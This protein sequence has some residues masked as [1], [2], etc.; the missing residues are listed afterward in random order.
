MRACFYFLSQ[1]FF[2]FDGTPCGNRPLALKVQNLN[3]W[4][5]REDPPILFLCPFLFLFSF[6]HSGLICSLFPPVC[7]SWVAFP[8]L[9][10]LQVA[11]WTSYLVKC[12]KYTEW[13][14]NQQ[15][16]FWV[17]SSINWDVWAR[18]SFWFF[19][20]YTAFRRFPPSTWRHMKMAPLCS[21]PPS[22]MSS[23]ALPSI[24]LC[25]CEISQGC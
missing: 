19:S 11:R 8:P 20:L 21:F 23:S 9:T 25:R 24:L 6:L 18:Y 17:S 16:P 22:P 2:S 15:G 12:H 4:T 13:A 7:I 3:H 1:Y 5:T 10:A 14:T